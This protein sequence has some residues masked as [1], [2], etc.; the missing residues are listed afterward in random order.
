LSFSSAPR[1][2]GQ[3][4]AIVPSYESLGVLVDSRFALKAAAEAR[5]GKGE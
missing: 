2:Q 5:A 3:D 1:L 4:V